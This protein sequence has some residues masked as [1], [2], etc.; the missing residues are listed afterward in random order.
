MSNDG[1]IFAVSNGT[2]NV[3]ELSRIPILI[4]LRY[5]TLFGMAHNYQE[6][7]MNWLA[8]KKEVEKY[9]ATAMEYKEYMATAMLSAEDME[10]Q[11]DNVQ[12]YHA[13]WTEC[14]DKADNYGLMAEALLE[15]YPKYNIPTSGDP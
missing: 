2:I 3:C 9:I 15:P 6:K 4:K 1:T 14:M 12:L 5:L 10:L 8:K 11:R 13:K 7:G